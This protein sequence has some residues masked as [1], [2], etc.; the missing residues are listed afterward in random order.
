VSSIRICAAY[1]RTGRKQ[2]PRAR[3]Q[4]IAP[5]S[6]Q[7]GDFFT[8]IV[9]VLVKG[10]EPIYSAGLGMTDFSGAKSRENQS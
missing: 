3:T 10:L 7:L 1:G 8:W 2:Q 9:S 6:Q 4:N 5:Y